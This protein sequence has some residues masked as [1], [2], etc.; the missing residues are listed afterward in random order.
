MQIKYRTELGRLLDHFGLIGPACEIGVAEGRNA[1]VL[2][3]EPAITELYLIDSWTQLTQKGDG[4]NK[5]EWHINNFKEAQERVVGYNKAVFLRGLSQDMIKTI[6]DDYLILAYV[7]GDHSLKGALNDLRAIWPKI[8][9][10]GILAGHDYLNPDYGVREAVN[11][12]INEVR[13]ET[14]DVLL[15]NLIEEDHFSMTGFWIRKK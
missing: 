2:V 15:V 10:G 9:S 4:G 11:T 6:S 13:K 3:K 14:G 7:D 12:F 1:E 5:Q 8:K